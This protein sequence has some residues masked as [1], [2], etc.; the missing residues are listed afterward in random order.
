MVMHCAESLS[1]VNT[2]E[3]RNHILSVFHGSMCSAYKDNVLERLHV[4]AL[5][6]IMEVLTL[7]INHH[8]TDNTDNRAFYL[9]IMLLPVI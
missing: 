6:T 4:Q 2:M 1:E 3:A 9:H 7:G 5:S 8:E